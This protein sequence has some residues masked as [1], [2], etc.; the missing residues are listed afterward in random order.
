ML[1]LQLFLNK[2]V[3]TFFF[4]YLY[5][6]DIKNALNEIKP[7]NIFLVQGNQCT[8]SFCLQHRKKKKT[9]ASMEQ[10]IISSPY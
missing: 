3:E 5:K 9:M 6:T 8:V 1:I 2:T 7:V 4:F 10:V